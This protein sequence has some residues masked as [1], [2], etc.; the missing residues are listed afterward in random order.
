MLNYD[1]THLDMC[2][3]IFE[4]EDRNIGVIKVIFI[5]GYERRNNI[6]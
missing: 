2:D 4:P 5:S 6:P 1:I 3:Y